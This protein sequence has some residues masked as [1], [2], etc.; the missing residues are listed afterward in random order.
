MMRKLRLRIETE[1]AEGRAVI[2]SSHVMSFVERVSDRVAMMKAGRIVALETPAELR[3]MTGL[4]DE[5][6]EDVFFQLA[7]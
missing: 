3:A 6:F 7:G 2:V 5:Q 1:R 4:M